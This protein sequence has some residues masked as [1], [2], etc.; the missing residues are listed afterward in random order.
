MELKLRALLPNPSGT[1]SGNEWVLLKNETEVQGVFSGY[2]LQ[3]DNDNPIGIG[4]ISL[5]PGE[6][7]KFTELRLVNSGAEI[8]LLYNG[9][10]VD[11]LS[12]IEGKSGIVYV[13]TNCSDD[14]LEISEDKFGPASVASDYCPP[15]QAETNETDTTSNTEKAQ[16]A[17]TKNTETD[18]DTIY[19][20]IN[21][22][23][24]M[25]NLVR[26]QSIESNSNIIETK[27]VPPT[28]IVPTIGLT[29]ANYLI[30]AFSVWVALGLY[31][32]FPNLWTALTAFLKRLLLQV[33]IYRPSF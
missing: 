33:G 26:E 12:Y 18:Y 20:S 19:K 23:I 14:L 11:S 5:D 22:S 10:T 25:E 4:D 8:K 17:P 30:L 6:S 3:R 27:T 7:Y 1:D 31:Y 9:E 24:R 2:Y 13:K 32:E 28:E 16:Q 21:N 29:T 15:D